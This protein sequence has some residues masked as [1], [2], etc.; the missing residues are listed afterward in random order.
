MNPEEMCY[1]LICGLEMKLNVILKVCY[2]FI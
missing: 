1:I 2:L